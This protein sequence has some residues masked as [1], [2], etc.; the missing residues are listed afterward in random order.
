[1][2]KLKEILNGVKN[3]IFISEEIEKIANKRYEICQECDKDSV[4]YDPVHPE[5]IG[6]YYSDLRPDEHCTE[7]AC[8]IYVKNRSL[9]T[10]CPIG[11][12]GPEVT[13]E[14]DLKIKNI[15]NENKQ[16]Q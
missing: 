5:K 1:M 15:L 14:E 10:K 7:C 8:N 9:T 3:S 13:Q 11:K 4:N 2:S 6:K 12:W 16:K